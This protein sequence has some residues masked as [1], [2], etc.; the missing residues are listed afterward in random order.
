LMFNK[1]L[2]SWTAIS[3]G[4]IWR[5]VES[6]REISGRQ[7]KSPRLDWTLDLFSGQDITTQ[8][9]HS[10]P[11]QTWEGGGPCVHSQSSKRVSLSWS[12]PDLFLPISSATCRFPS[13]KWIRVVVH[14][15]VHS[16]FTKHRKEFLA[17]TVKRLEAL[18]PL[19]VAGA[20]QVKEEVHVYNS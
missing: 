5:S 16:P 12:T 20:L 18:S 9:T 4:W 11:C 2:E 13:P 10:P 14:A 15:I 1:R 17:G 19:A 7:S 6:R 3:S 8:C